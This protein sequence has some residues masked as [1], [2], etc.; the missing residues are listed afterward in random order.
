MSS[1]NVGYQGGPGSYNLMGGSLSAVY[2]YIGSDIDKPS[3][4]SF[5]QSGGTNG[6]VQLPLSRLRGGT[7]SYNLTGGSLSAFGEYF[8]YLSEPA[9]SRSRVEPTHCP[10]ISTSDTRAV[11]GTI[12]SAALACYPRLARRN[13]SAI[14]QPAA[15]RS[16]AGPTPCPLALGTPVAAE[17]MVWAAAC[18]RPLPSSSRARLPSFSRRAAPTW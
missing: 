9:A 16:P 7:G 11:V 4:G 14:P 15:S 2:E 3:T 10:V 6:A 1:L 5:T 8:G 18:S 13:T 12:L 17:R